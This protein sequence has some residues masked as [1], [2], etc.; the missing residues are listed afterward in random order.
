MFGQ[1]DEEEVLGLSEG[2]DEEEEESEEEEEEFKLPPA[3]QRQFLASD[4]EEPSEKHQ[5]GTTHFCI[6]LFVFI[7][8]SLE[9]FILEMSDKAWGRK[10]KTFYA[11]EGIV[12]QK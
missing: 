12:L 2:E 11:V 9:T 8:K 3:L 7:V 10:K 4:D 6:L 1:A 5:T